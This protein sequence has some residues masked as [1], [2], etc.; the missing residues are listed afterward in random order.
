MI[1]FLQPFGIQS[2]GGGPRILRALLEDAPAPFLSIC[3]A[4]SPPEP[5]EWVKEEHLPLRFSLGPLE[6]RFSHHLWGLYRS[7]LMRPARRMQY[8]RFERRLEETLVKQGVSG[9]HAVAHGTTFR[10]AY[11]VARRLELPFYLTIH[12]DLPYNLQPSTPA[13][14]NEVT[15]WLRCAWRGATGRIVISEAMGEEYCR[16]F[17][18]LPYEVVTDG[19]SDV[20]AAPRPRSRDRL[21]VY[22]M[23]S[24]HVS[25]EPN[26]RALLAALDQ[27]GR[28]WPSGKISLTTRG[29]FPFDLRHEGVEVNELPWGSEADVEN[30]LRSAD[31][32]YLPLPFQEAFESF[33]RYSLSTKM[34]TYLGSGL[35]ILYHGPHHAAA[36]ALLSQHHAAVIAD[37]LDSNDLASHIAGS[38]DES[39]V[40]VTNALALGKKQFDLR[41]QR[42]KFWRMLEFGTHKMVDRPTPVLEGG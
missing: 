24:I 25:Y 42:E 39:D 11:R 21:R 7:A 1:A 18:K 4:Q 33:V 20:P 10:H 37:T 36:A 40:L 22:L 9:V 15:G 12:D 5:T 19:L 14:V 17:G 30:D 13:F 23:G 27:V 31:L 16:R 32:V 28:L 34:V 38:M 6:A 3:T 8:A 2:P 26:F 35:P 29:G 41:S